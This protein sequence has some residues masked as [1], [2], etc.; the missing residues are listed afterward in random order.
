MTKRS[1]LRGGKTASQRQLRVGEVLRHEL[2]QLFLRDEI[3]EPDL[4]GVI[5]TV[6]EVSVSP[7]LRKARAYIM[8]LGGDNQQPVVEALNRAHKFIRGELSRKLSLKYAPEIEFVIDTSFDYSQ[9]IDDVLNT[10]EVARDTSLN[11]GTT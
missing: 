5:I 1:S 3:R 9:R 10:P 2:A 7:D 6:S 8:P 4:K 11:D